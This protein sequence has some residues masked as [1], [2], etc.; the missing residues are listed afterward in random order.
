MEL[1]GYQHSLM[2]LIDGAVTCQRLLARS[3]LVVGAQRSA[4]PAAIRMRS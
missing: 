4:M 3:R 1:F 2:A